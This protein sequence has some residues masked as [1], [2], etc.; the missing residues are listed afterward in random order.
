MTEQG[1]EKALSKAVFGYMTTR[2]NDSSLNSAPF[3]TSDSFEKKINKLIKSEHNLY[4]KFTL[5]KARRLL[6]A[7]IIIILLL[8]SSLSVGA[9]REMIANFFVEHFNN[10]DSVSSNTDNIIY[11]TKLEKLYELTFIPPGYTLVSTDIIDIDAT[12]TYTSEN[13]YFIFSQNV[14]KG[15][16]TNIDNE[17]SVPSI[18]KIDEQIIY[19]YDHG[20]QYYTYLWND[21]EYIFSITGGKLQNN[22]F[23]KM[24]HSLKLK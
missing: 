15:F 11:P 22:I 18:M 14:C 19:V 2:L 4:Y 10:H 1:F 5:T 3:K 13:D 6:C 12:F 24:Y 9:V 17:F 23:K 20:N 7:A 21:K 8:A 16:T